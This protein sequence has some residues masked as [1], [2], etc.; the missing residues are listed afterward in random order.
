MFKEINTYKD[1]YL[2]YKCDYHFLIGRTGKVFNEQ[3]IDTPSWR[4]TNYEANLI[5]IGICFLGN[6]EHIN[7]PI[8]K[9][10]F[11]GKILK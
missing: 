6:F 8:L 1:K 5:S 7:T 9:L 11:Y 4:C 10:S 2:N 3:P